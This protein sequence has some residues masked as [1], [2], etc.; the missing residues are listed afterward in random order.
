[1]T[2]VVPSWLQARVLS[3][4]FLIKL[5]FHFD[6]RFVS[7]MKTKLKS[8]SLLISFYYF[9]VYQSKR[10]SLNP[11]LVPIITLKVPFVFLGFF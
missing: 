5:V 1:M 7:L 6:I 10:F 11:L 2:P 3:D 9:S 8:N 4:L